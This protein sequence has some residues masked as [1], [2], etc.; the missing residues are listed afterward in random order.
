M[1]IISR[2][3]GKP[4]WLPAAGVITVLRLLAVC[5]KHIQLWNLLHKHEKLRTYT[6]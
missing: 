4:V 6:K 2:E 3:L 5:L 1:I